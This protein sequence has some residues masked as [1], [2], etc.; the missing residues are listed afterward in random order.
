MENLEKLD[1]AI[2]KN[3]GQVQLKNSIEISGNGE[4]KITKVLTAVATPIIENV[5]VGNSEINFDGEVVYDLLVILENG[6][7]TP[8]SE[9]SKFNYVYENK[10]IV[11]GASVEIIPN[12]VD[13]S[14]SPKNEEFVF[15]SLIDFDI[16]QITQTC[17]LSCA[18]C[19][20]GVFAKEEELSFFSMVDTNTYQT[21]INF[22]FQKDSKVNRIMYV[23]NYACI[24][25]IM[26]SVDYFVVTGEIYS[27]IVYM[28]EKGVIKSMVKENIFSEE[29]EAKGIDK[30]CV[31]QGRVKVGEGVV[32][33]NQDGNKFLVEIPLCIETHIFCKR[34]KNCVSDAYNTK[35]EVQLTTSS[36]IEE[37][38]VAIKQID[39]NILTNFSLTDNMPKI[40]KILAVIPTNIRIVN[41]IVK[42]GE[43]L[44]EGIGSI[45]LIYYTEDEE[46]NNV[47]NSVDVDFPFSLSVSLSDLQENSNVLSN[48]VFGDVNVKS[49]RGLELE[50]LAEVKL[51]FNL[52][53]Q[54]IS[55]LTTDI[56]LGEEKP[57]KDYA[58]E[59]YLAKSNQTLWD[60]GKELNQDVTEITNQNKDLTIPLNDGDKIVCYNQLENKVE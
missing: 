21:S 11:E 5:S 25:S 3:C 41:Q 44:I 6:E 57:M 56:V 27:N 36:L 28:N 10:E 55:S 17:D 15:N 40:D 33:E 8:L 48:I 24:K 20:E 22:E 30:D 52:S 45:N 37:E 18:V 39:E 51:N 13:L 49:K 31:V 7:I 42:D 43:L 23:K 34:V 60:I 58:L 26:P 2:R 19:P 16:Y 9:K 14:S 47:L 54:N 35:F 12:L 59:I 29:V 4:N 46:G 53:K 50:I 38:F 1:V 32:Q